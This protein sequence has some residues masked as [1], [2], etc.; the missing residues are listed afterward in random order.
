MR[1]LPG[2]NRRV[3]GGGHRIDVT[4]AGWIGDRRAQLVVPIRQHVGRLTGDHARHL[5][6]N[7]GL[8]RKKQRQILLADLPH[9]ELSGASDARQRLVIE[10]PDAVLGAVRLD[11]VGLDIDG[12]S[13]RQP[14]IALTGFNV[15]DKHIKKNFS[16]GQL[17]L[18]DRRGNHRD[19][20]GLLLAGNVPG[21]DQPPRQT[22]GQQQRL[23][24]R[25]G[26]PLVG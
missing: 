13:R 26:G 9:R 6:V 16:A 19:R 4:R 2:G 22:G 11:F 12:K 25:A 18:L 1:A 3:R 14:Q 15:V 8:R 23:A 7:R 17:A 20:H 21:S 24:R 5:D 10:F